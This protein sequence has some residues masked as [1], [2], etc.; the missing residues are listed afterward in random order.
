MRK[1]RRLT[2]EELTPLPVADALTPVTTARSSRSNEDS[3]SRRPPS[4][5]YSGFQS[6]AA[7]RIQP[8]QRTR[9]RSA[10]LV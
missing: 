6:P 1:P 10:E 9:F 5:E 8:E 3:G 7:A 2:P 4:R